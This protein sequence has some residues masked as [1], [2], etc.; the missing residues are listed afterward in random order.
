MTTEVITKLVSAFVVV[1]FLASTA[2][3]QDWYSIHEESE[4]LGD[5][6][7][8]GYPDCGPADPI[9]TSMTI[10]F[11][12]TDLSDWTYLYLEAVGV[13]PDVENYQNRI[14]FNDQHVGNLDGY[15]GIDCDDWDTFFEVAIDDL[16][17][18]GEN[19]IRIESGYYKVTGEWDDFWVRH[20]RLYSQPVPV[21]PASWSRI[22][23][24]YR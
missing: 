6:S 18:V 5:Q 19:D 2:A 24:A 4:H 17:L 13:D 7:Y 16:L 1:A 8:P 23:A 10:T 22:K 21:T 15:P 14:F 9:G 20:I 11:E 12:I 3:G